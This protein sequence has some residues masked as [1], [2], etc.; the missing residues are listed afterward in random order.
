MDP[1]LPINLGG[2]ASFSYESKRTVIRLEH[3]EFQVC[4]PIER[5]KIEWMGL[6]R[7]RILIHRT[8]DNRWDVRII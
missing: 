6:R 8:E 4:Q 2:Q 7:R 5:E 1:Q 3:G